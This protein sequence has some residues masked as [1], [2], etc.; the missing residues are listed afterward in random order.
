ML[1]FRSLLEKQQ[2]AFLISQ[3]SPKWITV[4]ADVIGWAFVVATAIVI[5]N[6]KGTVTTPAIAGFVMIQVF[7]VNAL[8]K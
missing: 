2:S 6:G 5:C 4:R 3:L 7:R 8:N 1:R